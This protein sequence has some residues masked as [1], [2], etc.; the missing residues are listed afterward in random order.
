MKEILT[1]P[2][3]G[4]TTPMKNSILPIFILFCSLTAN[5][6]AAKPIF[7]KQL[8]KMTLDIKIDLGARF[9]TGS[10]LVN[11]ATLKDNEIMVDGIKVIGI[12]KDGKWIPFTIKDGKIVPRDPIYLG[13][14]TLSI[15]FEKSLGSTSPSK[16][17]EF[18]GGSLVTDDFLLLM[19]RW[20]PLFSA[21]AV[22]DLNVTVKEGIAV[23]SEADDIQHD[24]DNGYEHFKFLFPYP[25]EEINL[26]AG[27]FHVVQRHEDGLTI[28]TYFLNGDRDLSNRF[29]QKAGSL[30]NDFGKRIS[31]Y[32]FKR[33]AIVESPAPSGLS[34]PTFTL[35]GQQILRKPFVIEVSLGHEILHS[36]F[37]NSVYVDYSG[38]NW[39]EGLTT[40]LADNYFSEQK[41]KG[42]EYRHQILCDYKSYVHDKN[43]FPVSAFKTRYDRASKAIGYGK[44]ALIFHMLKRLCGEKAFYSA[45]S[46]FSL[47]YRFKKASW[48]DIERIF[49]RHS[50]RDLSMFF[51]QWLQRKDI[52]VIKLTGA[53]AEQQPDGQFAFTAHVIQET[54]QPYRLQVPLTLLTSSGQVHKEI[55]L[56]KKQEKISINLAKRPLMAIIDENFDIM[57]DLAPNE[58]PP[59]LARLFGA[60]KRFLIL[61]TEDNREKYLPLMEFFE[62]KG[63][64][65]IR[66]KDLK[67]AIL[68]TGSFVLLGEAKGKLSVFVPSIP[69]LQKGLIV[70]VKAN[71][72]DPNLV[73]CA[74]KASSAEQ[75]SKAAF[76][77]PHYGRYAFL[78]FENGKIVEK[79][80]AAYQ[81]GLRTDVQMALTGIKSSA[82][83]GGPEIIKGLSRSK[84]IYLGERHDQQGIHDAQLK[85]IASLGQKAP[86]AVAME[87]FQRPFQKVINAYLKREISEKEFLKKTE[88]FKRW[89]FNYHFYRP[90]VEYCRKHH[91]PI[92]AMNLAAEI[93]KK[94]ARSGIGSLSKKERSALPIRLDFSNKLYRQMLWDIYQGH[95]NNTLQDFHHFFQ[96]QIAWDETMANSIAD[97]LKSEPRRKVIVI[98]GAGHVVY[99]YGIPDR[100]KRRL[101]DVR[102]D[103]VIFPQG[104]KI[105]P[106]EATYFLFVPERKEPFVAKL[107]VLLSGDNNLKVEGVIPDSPAA[108]GGMKKG[109]VIKAIDGQPVKDIYDLKL[110]LFFKQKGHPTR[111]TVVR[112][113]R[114]GAQVTKDVTT[115]PLVPFDWGGGKPRFHGKR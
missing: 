9:L 88:Y 12:K 11:P 27:R 109:D 35:I 63:F 50:G 56:G 55:S 38:G 91:V 34:F 103:I 23:V 98:V 67:H 22:Y 41:G 85:I 25:R 36:W 68:K 95:E 16:R 17:H 52:P 66:R 29:L 2:D 32:P 62:R 82:I 39:C 84:V 69:S 93:S 112:T 24:T 100:V 43:A 108:K 14:S 97:F 1:R 47:R 102:Q 75:C 74:I 13:Q 19:S 6:Q 99:G 115:G 30:I 20:C 65:P 40:Y 8:P 60:E 61:P 71:P 80:E 106:L 83:E 107:G 57:R 89:G 104:E 33:F 77:L 114:N 78:K 46:D 105:D 64:E 79:K 18:L 48:R 86:I 7:M 59:S 42:A 31:P 45:I 10:A 110:E 28:A 4:E 53:Q 54:K 90:I 3:K 72:F 94:I 81:C 96:A 21:P 26:V 101:G 5:A 37:G 44:V 73:T 70:K 113:G 76:K 87:M 58:F 51:S 15:S 92:I 111:I 49:S